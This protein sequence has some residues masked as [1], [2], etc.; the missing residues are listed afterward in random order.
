MRLHG[1][2]VKSQ[3]LHPFFRQLVERGPYLLAIIL[4][5][6]VVTIVAL[7]KSPLLS[8]MSNII[9][10]AYQRADPR[11]WN[12]DAP[13]RIV[14][15]DDE[16]LARIGQWPWPRSTLAGLVDRLGELGAAAVAFDIVF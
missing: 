3:R 4:P 7:A 9:F 11:P 1:R 12:P 8:D 15:I 10:D 14:D 13:I 2:E 6:V 5:I 16:S